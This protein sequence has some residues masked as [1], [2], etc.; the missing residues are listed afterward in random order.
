MEMIKQIDMM[1]DLQNVEAA[2]EQAKN[3][4]AQKS[5]PG[6]KKESPK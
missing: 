4:P 3:I 6:P 2:G 1:Q 5:V